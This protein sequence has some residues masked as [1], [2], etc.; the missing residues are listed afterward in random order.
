MKYVNSD[1]LTI[2][3]LIVTASLPINTSASPTV[4]GFVI[5]WTEEGW[6]QVQFQGT[7]ESVCNGG[8][9][10]TVPAGVYTVIN[11]GTGQRFM[12]IAV[13]NVNSTID[14]QPGAPVL[15]TGQTMS[16]AAGDDGDYQLGVSASSQ[17][18]RDN[19]DG[20]FEDTLTGLTW[21]G[22]R[23]CVPLHTWLVSLDFANNFSANSGDC[24]N[25][26]DN[27]KAGDWRMP[28][29]REL[30]SLVN[31][32]VAFPAWEPDIPFSGDW[33]EDPIS[34]AY[35]SSTSFKGSNPETNAYTLNSGVGLAQ[36]SGKTLRRQY[37]LP[38]RDSQ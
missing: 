10:C 24:P 34:G 8:R 14:D 22:M 9:Q 12:N 36:A 11:H 38:V 23:D 21:L 32:S 13:P 18:F 17:R 20:T 30:L 26:S 5:R 33:M 2:V 7:Y 25:L 16:Y 6:H 28:N 29:I 19:G 35:W 31:F 15:S 1:I 37:I 4:D 3:A 27:S